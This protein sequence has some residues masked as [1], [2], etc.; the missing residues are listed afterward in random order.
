MVLDFNWKIVITK[1][2]GTITCDSVSL[3]M[4]IIEKLLKASF[5]KEVINDF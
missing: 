5:D 3:R 2:N 4:Q 1:F